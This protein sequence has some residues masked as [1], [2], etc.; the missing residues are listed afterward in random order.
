VLSRE[1]RRNQILEAAGGQFMAYGFAG[2][3][4]QGIAKAAGISR[5]S[6][7]T[8]FGNKMEVFHAVI[9]LLERFISQQ[10]QRAVDELNPRAPFA[11]RLVATFDT[12]QTA[13]LSVT[14]IQSPYTYELLQLRAENTARFEKT[15]FEE[16]IVTMIE[17]AT[18]SGEFTPK[19]GTPPA[20][21]I[22]TILVQSTSGIALFE[23]DDLSAK[24]QNLRLLIQSFLD[25]LTG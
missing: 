8:Y 5:A 6:L 21:V 24:R 3:S 12:R 17:D 18:A 4:M 2:A 15:P 11:A 1:E 23:G 25:G 10:A 22:A 13:W 19:A 20:S 7:Y 16:L 9:K 14:N